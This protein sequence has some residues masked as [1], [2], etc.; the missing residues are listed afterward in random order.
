MLIK[1]DPDGKYKSSKV[2]SSCAAGTGS[3]LDQQAVRLNLSGIE[4]L[5]DRAL[6][7]NEEIPG[8]A[9]RCA[10]FSRTDIIHAQQR[11]FSVNAICNSLCKG[12]SENIINTVF[13]REAPELPILLTGGVSRNQVVRRYLEKQ[14]KTKFLYN[15]D[16]HFA[17]A[18]GA[19]LLLLEGKVTLNH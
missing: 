10:V 7:N 9:S 13:N 4:E 6:N 11:G 12:L 3:F 5:C 2:N 18:I 14:L 1:F 15:E 17:G 8:I 19:G 16:S